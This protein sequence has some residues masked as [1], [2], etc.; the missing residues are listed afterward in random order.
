MDFFP[1]FIEVIPYAYVTILILSSIVI[2]CVPQV[3]HYLSEVMINVLI[4]MLLVNF[5]AILLISPPM[6]YLLKYPITYL[7][8]LIIIGPHLYLMFIIWI[9]MIGMR[10]SRRTYGHIWNVAWCVTGAL[11]S[12]WSANLLSRL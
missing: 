11:G 4:L 2:I 12:F 6:K 3:K 10:F 8:Q 1:I 5:A 9:F 7:Y